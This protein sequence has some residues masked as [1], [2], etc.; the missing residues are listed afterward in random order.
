MQCAS[1]NIATARPQYLWS[2]NRKSVEVSGRHSHG[3]WKLQD[4]VVSLEGEG[5]DCSN[6]TIEHSCS[7]ASG[8]V[9]GATAILLLSRDA[10]IL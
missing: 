3:L 8:L 4:E 6:V 1:H 10:L 5:R 7:C 9:I 2:P